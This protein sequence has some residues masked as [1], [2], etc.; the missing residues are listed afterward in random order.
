MTGRNEFNMSAK[1]GGAS[2]RMLQN[3]MPPLPG[4]C[5]CTSD[6]HWRFSF[7]VHRRVPRV[8]AI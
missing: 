6:K 1:L 4:V 5:R 7:S 2:H 3:D 8:F